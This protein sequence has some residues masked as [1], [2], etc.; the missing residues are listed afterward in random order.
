MATRLSLLGKA[1]L[2]VA[3]LGSSPGGAQ[4]VSVWP[5]PSTVDL[6]AMTFGTDAEVAKKG[7][8][9]FFFH[10][11]DLT[12]EEASL[13]FAECRS[14][15]PRGDVRGLPTFVPWV[16]TAERKKSEQVINPYGLVGAAMA[17]IILPKVDRGIRNSKMRMCME[18]RG[19]VRYALN[20]EAYDLLNE[21]DNGNIVA[22]QAKL[23]TGPAPD[24]P[25][26]TP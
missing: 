26:V 21:G 5:D 15:L 12:Y 4:D 25:R 1:C 9:F 14:H 6:P 18:R 24:A 8:K 23:A 19:Y 17:A 2:A 22:M 7:Y 20:E 3:F 11:A 16:E 13:D 10:Q